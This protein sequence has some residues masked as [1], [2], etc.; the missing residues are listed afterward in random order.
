M[1]VSYPAMFYYDASE[2]VPYFV[3]FPDFKNSA[4]QGDSISDAMFMA[5][6]WLGGMVAS[7]IEDDQDIPTP[8]SI[9]DLSLEG[10]NPFKDDP[11]FQLTYDKD[12]SFISMV[13]VN[14][15]NYIDDQKT[16]K[17]TLTIPELADKAGKKM[18]LNFSKTLTEDIAE[19]KLRQN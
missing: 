2:S 9:N 6:D 18:K 17:K 4:T 3:H 12:K 14:V 5:S 7:Y 11:D 8:T 13:T 1:L 19:K 16:V 10:N 15:T